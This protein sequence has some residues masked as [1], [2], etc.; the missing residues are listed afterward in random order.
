LFSSNNEDHDMSCR[1][2]TLLKS[3]VRAGIGATRIPKSAEKQERATL[4][5]ALEDSKARYATF[6]G[7]IDAAF[8]ILEMV[9]RASRQAVDYLFVEVSAGFSAHTGLENP[10][11]KTV[12]ALVSSIHKPWVNILARADRTRL[13]QSFEGPI[14]ALDQRW[15]ASTA[16]PIGEPLRHRVAIIFNNVKSKRE[17]ESALER[18]D[19]SLK[20]AAVENA[21]IAEAL[22]CERE[23]AHVTLNS[24][25]DAVICTGVAGEVVYLNVVAERLTGW[26]SMDAIGQRL[27]TVFHIVESGTRELLPNPMTLAMAENKIAALPTLR[28]L[29]RRNATDLF[30][31]DSCAPIHDR[32]GRVTGAVVVFHDMSAT[33]GLSRQLIHQAAHD[34]LTDLPNRSLLSVR[35]TQAL[36]TVRRHQTSLA[37]LYLDLDRF[38]HINDSLGHAIGDRLLQTIASRLT[39][40]LRASDTVSRQGGDEFI[41]ML[42]DIDGDK[43]AAICAEKVLASLRL[44]YVLDEYELHMSASIG[45]ALCP[46]DGS[47]VEVLLKNADSAMYE[48]KERGRNNYQ[49]YRTDLNASAS[50]RQTLESSLRHALERQ[51]LEL[52]YQPIV[53][54]QSGV[55]AGVESL[56]RWRHP[57]YGLLMPS[58]FMAIAEESGLIV[59]IGS[60]VLRT[61]CLQAREWQVAGRPQLRYAVNVSAVELRSNGFVEGVAAII[62]ETSID[63]SFLE[64][65][66]TETFLAQ[67]SKSTALVL[68][69]LK[70]LHVHLA[71]DDFGTGY[72][73][74]SYMRR[75]PI[76][77][78]K[79]D[80]SFVTDLTTDPDDASVVSAIINMG[81]SLHKR[82]I[83]EGVETH[84][85]LSFLEAQHC[86]EA[87]GFLFGRPVAADKFAP[88][89]QECYQDRQQ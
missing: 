1:R 53:D 26:T 82:V 81:K 24:I 42:V 57:Q 69:S 62:E 14:A 18:S 78:L 85:Q 58:D 63:P 41:M 70:N 21:V 40:C 79:I 30:I 49:F 3:G 64:L 44:P 13:P 11:G 12:R 10:V 23:R 61:T 34:H 33:R 74:L 52:Y 2:V 86:P 50:A 65:E 67:D 46:Q 55:V 37:I 72:S 59:P 16:F 39:K 4:R 60:W 15:F 73:S 32:A 22:Y 47:G 7:P 8:C 68:R 45:I 48:A 19:A 71:L 20:K 54:L 38:K 83:A 31:E 56:L 89:V 17:T 27:E 25:G 84:E 76:D 28:T 88:I 87:Q 29:V 66:L 9:P 75:F 77:T 51:Q 36:A 35:L 43:D 80:R 5:Q 6:S